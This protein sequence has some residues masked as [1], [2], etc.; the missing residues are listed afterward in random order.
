MY[1]YLYIDDEGKDTSEALASGLSSKNVTVEYKHVS[2][3]DTEF[4]KNNLDN[5][6]GIVLDLRLD[7][8]PNSSNFTATEFAQHIRTLVTKK[9]DLKKDLP[10]VLFSTDDKLQQVYAI[11]LSSHNL[12]DSYYNKTETDTHANASNELF[13]LAEG[14]IEINKNKNNLPALMGLEDLYD[15]NAEIFARFDIENSNIPIHEYAQVI[16]KDLIY[17]TGALID[18]S[19]LASRLGVDIKSKNWQEVKELFKLAK[20]QGVFSDGWDRWWMFK[21]NEIFK[22]EFNT[23][24][25]YLNAEEKCQ[26]FIEKKNISDISSPIPIKFNSSNRYTTVC[27]VLNRPLDA[28]EGYRVYTTKP[29]KQWQEYSYA[30][31]YAFAEKLNEEKKIAVHPEDRDSLHDALSNL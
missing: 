24:L 12:F 9:E 19:I 11:D 18:E 7:D 23:Y 8:T 28:I 22:K 17:V 27:K 20:Y 29:L 30:S 26:L 4:I 13:A 14:Y 3:F 6:D 16:L 15:L 25:S 10:I 21:I 1:R 2:I 31:L 5:Y